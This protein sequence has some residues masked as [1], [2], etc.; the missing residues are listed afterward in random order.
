MLR[1]VFMGCGAAALAL[2]APLAHAATPPSSHVRCDGRPDN[3]TDGELAA[4][5]V[6]ISLVVGL[7]MGS[8]E[9]VDY[10]KREKAEAGI[11][12]CDAAI[13][14]DP[15][16]KKGAETNV[17]R[18]AELVLARAVHRIEAKQADAAIADARGLDA[19]AGALAATPAYARSLG[20]S[21]MEVE[22]GALLSLGK[23]EEA[24]RIGLKMAAASPYDV[25][26]LLRAG[27]YILPDQT[28]DE[29]KR[30]WLDAAV[31]MRP[32]ALMT[33]I[34]H[35]D[36]AGDYLGASA[37]MAAFT[38]MF[39]AV[40]EKSTVPPGFAA[41]DAVR[42]L[43]AGDVD[44]AKLLAAQAREALP[45]YAASVEGVRNSDR[46]TSA[47]ELIDFYDI[48]LKL[49][50]GRVAEARAGFA[51][52]SRWGAVPVPIVADL[53]GRLRKGASPAELTGPL[54]ATPE[55]LR[56]DARAGWLKLM[57]EE[58]KSTER[59]FGAVRGPVKPGSYTA[60]AR[61]VWRTDK[62]R[63]LIARKLDGSAYEGVVVTG[64]GGSAA[65]E[66]LL[67]HCALVA[68]ARG[69]TGFALAPIRKRVDSALVAFGN[70]GDRGVPAAVFIDAD[71]VIA[72]LSPRIPQ[73]A[74]R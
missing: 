11:K 59:L 1:H 47:A 7:L 72:A 26:N 42:H 70:P 6:A 19:V 37:D 63:Y 23:Q 74:K 65:G 41:L 29:A 62:S 51:A 14:G 32:E 35:R 20:L 71:A 22:A 69:K 39:D 55:E 15:V 28:L 43:M 27:Y 52:R 45:A 54:A 73:P 61:N 18:K 16:A 33:R 56:A 13:D 9:G 44:K 46:L 4:R 25:Y 17:E 3:M 8:P 12:A 21:A 38:A 64:V 58:P 48:V 68:K 49:H 31:R 2:A 67:L 57:T 30:A 24:A 53:L 60:A 66:A 40:A 10:S 34:Q 5:L 50:E 36:W